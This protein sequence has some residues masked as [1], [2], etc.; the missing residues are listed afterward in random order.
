MLNLLTKS[1]K[2][3]IVVRNDIKLSKGK[4][5]AQVAH[6]SLSAYKEAVKMRKGIVDI[7]ERTGMEKVVLKVNS[8]K[9]LLELYERIKLKL[10]CALIR[11][12]GKTQV[13]QNTIT[14]LGI[15]PWEEEIIDNYTGNLKLL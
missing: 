9:E 14:C 11:D 13:P 1:I 4:L 10:P 7:W 6:A 12:A 5:A 3:V 8:E 2:Q 15:G